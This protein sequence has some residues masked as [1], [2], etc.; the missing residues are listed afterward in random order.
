MASRNRDQCQMGK[1][2][3]V[4]RTM[5][6]V[7]LNS[8]GLMGLIAATAAQ[9][10]ALPSG[11]SVAAGNA[12]IATSGTTT[13]TQ[14]S[15]NAVINWASFSVGA[16]NS[17]V[18]HDASAAGATLNRVTGSATSVIAGQITS[19]GAVYLVNPNGIV[20]TSTGS[21]D[22]AGGFV[23]STLDL[24]D[25][26]FLAGR[27]NFKGHGAYVALLGGAV[28]NSGTI[29]VPLG[30]LGLGSGE[31]VAL[32]LNGSNFMQVTVPTSLITGSNALVSNSGEIVVSG[33]AVQLKAAVLKDAV[34]NVINMSGSISADSAVGNGGSIQLIGGADTGSMAGQVTVSGTLSARAT[35]ASGDGG[36]IETSGEHVD[37]NGASVSTASAHGAAGTWLIDP[38]D[39][40][41]ADSGGDMT[42]TALTTALTQGNVIIASRQGASGTDGDI[43]IN[44]AVNWS[45]NTLTL[46][47][48]R[49]IN[50]NAVMSA[51]GAAGFLGITG[52]TG[53]DGTSTGGAL[54]FGLGASGFYGRLDLAATG[55]FA[56][57][58]NIY[59]IITA[60]GDAGS[61]TGTDLQGINGNLSGYYVLGASIDASA[62]SGWNNG[63]GFASLG[64]DGAGNIWNGSAYVSPSWFYNQ[65][66]LPAGGF[67]GQFVGLGHT[68]NNLTIN[69]ASG[70]YTGLFGWTAGSISNVGVIG[71][72]IV[73]N[74]NVSGGLAGVNSGT[75]TN[76][77]ATGNVTSGGALVGGLVGQNTGTISNA[78]ATGNV[79]DAGGYS[80]GL[81]GAMRARLPMPMP[82]ER[83]RGAAL[84]PLAA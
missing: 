16:G 42:G 6:I 62:T 31:Q 25:A 41:V 73:N 20:I 29:I 68:V 21:V 45:A 37:L 71:G 77:Y 74:A 35:G 24:A 8:T 44:S 82:P 81:V 9:A 40:T 30:K 34:R 84:A 47:A 65:A 72:S 19:N 18:F 36:S 61:T 69:Q 57:N 56:L 70:G 58:G 63:A 33:G 79:I 83:C 75:I 32:D 2:E 80:G 51:S 76:S 49:N 39:F 4:G 17:V 55:S 38:V 48:Y 23:A 59:T 60:L 10:G 22:T 53:G 3:Q 52:D 26:D 66:Q 78:Y 15:Q 14:T 67:T 43:T 5:R 28:A 12:T 54:N 13:I 11:G 50:V 7:L 1:L 27:L 46:D 64:T